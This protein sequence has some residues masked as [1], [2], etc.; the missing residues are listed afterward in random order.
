MRVSRIMSDHYDNWS[1]N[2]ATDTFSSA[3]TQVLAHP[4]ACD[5]ASVARFPDRTLQALWKARLQMLERTR[6]WAQ[7]LSVGQSRRGV[8][9]DGLCAV[10]LLFTGQ[11]V[12]RQ[13]SSGSRDSRRDL[14]NQPGAAAPSRTT[15]RRPYIGA[16]SGTHTGCGSRGPAGRQY[17]RSLAGER[18]GCR[19]DTGGL[20]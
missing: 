8:P 7:V 4:V 10:S 6:S 12:A 1:D 18:L 16:G 17:A 20:R 19:L 2:E 3:Q 11:R 14:P 13:L 15:I 5:G 9:P